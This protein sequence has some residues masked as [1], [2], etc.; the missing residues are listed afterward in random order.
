VIRGAAAALL[1][2]VTA[3]QLPAQ[4]TRIT[5][6]GFGGNFGVA[7]ADDF[8]AGY[9]EASSASIYTV[10]ITSANTDRVTS[11]FVR[12]TS[13]TAGAGKPVSDLI[14]RRDDVSEWNEITTVNELVEARTMQTNG[15]SW[16][17]SIWFRYRLSWE[18]D[19]AAS[20]S[21]TIT[22]TLVVSAT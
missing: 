14:W 4:G 15:T 6:G 12:S 8:I 9:R 5:L 11:V 17:N 20:Y 2:C 16:S 3:L 1:I 21:T 10:L 13:G 19:F 22:L 7:T 18:S